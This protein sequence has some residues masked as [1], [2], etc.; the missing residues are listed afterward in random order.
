MASVI[1]PATGGEPL[2]LEQRIYVTPEY[3]TV[4]SRPFYYL[5]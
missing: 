3:C 5:L 2:H 1:N 4:E